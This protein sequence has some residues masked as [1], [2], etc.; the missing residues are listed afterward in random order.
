MMQLIFI[1]DTQSHVMTTNENHG[2]TEILSK[3][4]DVGEQQKTL[5]GESKKLHLADL[6]YRSNGTTPGRE[7]RYRSLAKS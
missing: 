6:E 2:L 4:H 5:E 1:Y 7:L 3:K